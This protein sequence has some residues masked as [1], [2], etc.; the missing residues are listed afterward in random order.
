MARFCQGSVALLFQYWC[1]CVKHA[2]IGTHT[3]TYTGCSSVL[4]LLSQRQF[5]PH[6]KKKISHFLFPFIVSTHPWECAIPWSEPYFLKRA[7]QASRYR[8]TCFS[9]AL[10]WNLVKSHY[11]LQYSKSQISSFKLLRNRSKTRVSLLCFLCL[12]RRGYCLPT[13]NFSYTCCL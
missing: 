9:P 4:P 8:S 12:L 11:L 10:T 5:K 2:L 7:S 3:G 6:N 1:T 13:Q